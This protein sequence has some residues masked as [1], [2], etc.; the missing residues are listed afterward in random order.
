MKQLIFMVA[1]T[2]AGTVGVYVV[3]PFWGVAVYYLFAVLRPQYIW[4]WSL[5][6]GVS[7]SF[8][9][10]LATIGAAVAGYL[11]V[12][13]GAEDRNAPPHKMCRA[14]VWVLLF[15]AW[16]MLTYFSAQS[17]EAAFPW[18]IEYLKIFVMFAV[19]FSLTRT[20]GQVWALFLITGLAL[21]YIA[22]EVNFLY[23][24]SGYLGIFHKGYGGL[25]NNG[26]GLMLA[27][28]VPLCWFAYEGSRGWWRLGFV[29]L[30]PPLIHAVLMTYSRGAMVSLL[31]VCP[32]ILLRSRYRVRLALGGGAL[33]VLAIPIMAGPQ[34]QARF[35]TL[36]NH[37][38]DESANLRWASWGA[39]LEIVKDY[40]VWGVG[41]RNANLFSHLHGA[42]KEG[43]TIHSQY[44]Q[45][46]ADN[47]LVGLGLYLAM[48]GAGLACTWRCRRAVAGRDDPEGRRI[49]AI[50]CGVEC[51]LI[52][53][54]VGSAFLSLEVFELSYLLLLLGA[55]LAVVSG[56]AEPAR[57][58]APAGGGP[59]PHDYS[60]PAQPSP[61]AG[62]NAW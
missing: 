44:L 43:R 49:Q 51:S 22:Y 57:W 56:A 9:V 41:I 29:L 61:L 53:Y 5:P 12:G 18:L 59:L 19:A 7:W 36:S 45:V 62:P 13:L 38:V 8:Y 23:L 58:G 55:Q 48:L 26:A 60:L 21:A 40:P 52:L 47:G 50:A 37:E 4:D 25:D 39:A 10:A 35:F 1:M 20:V 33:L 24:G 6:S 28:G 15:G 17:R 3:S 46:A 2:L 31:A 16:V 34:I 32:M 54:C 42:D 30:I 27:M 11:G 14:H